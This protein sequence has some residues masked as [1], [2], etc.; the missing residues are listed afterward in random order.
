VSPSASAIEPIIGNNA[1]AGIRV[2]NEANLREP[3]SQQEGNRRTWFI[4]CVSV[5]SPRPE[6]A[7]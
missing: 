5:P 2:P 7:R 3:V 6:Q 1:L 4:S